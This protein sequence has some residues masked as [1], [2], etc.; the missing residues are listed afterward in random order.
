M[1][2]LK[3]KALKKSS[4]TKVFEEILSELMKGLNEEPIKSLVAEALSA[5]KNN[6]KLDLDVKKLQTK[7]NNIKQQWRK[8]RDK[9]KMS[10]SGIAAPKSPDWFQIVNPV[11]SDTNQLM[12]NICSGPE[13]TSLI[14]EDEDEDFHI[15]NKTQTWDNEELVDPL[16]QPESE[17]MQDSENIQETE[18]DQTEIIPE[19]QQNLSCDQQSV[20]DSSTTHDEDMSAT[21]DG[22]RNTTLT[23]KKVVSKPHE[24]RTVA[25]SQLQAI[26]QLASGVNKLADVNA[27]RMK[28][29]EK[30]R[31]ALLNFR[32]EEAE[33]NRQHEK[34]MAEMYFQMMH[35]QNQRQPLQHI[36]PMQHFQQTAFIPRFFQQPNPFNFTSSPIQDKDYYKKN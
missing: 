35:V 31:L 18:I 4:T 7:Y 24:K 34:E 11:L 17:N 2:T 12:D 33:R 5:K 23:Q 9:Q 25:R 1:A 15:Q 32:R 36:S 29:E 16:Y 27:K 26:S 13:D 8:I 3:Q 14:Y 10:G 21:S 22:Y 19:T 6:R 28:I 30:D 20:S